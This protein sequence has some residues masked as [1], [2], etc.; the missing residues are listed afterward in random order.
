[1]EL[2]LIGVRRL[3]RDLELETERHFH[4][5]DPDEYAG[6]PAAVAQALRQAW[7]VPDGPIANL[8][9]LIESAGGVVLKA[10]FGTNK[11][12]GMSCWERDA[13]PLF[14]LNSRMAPEDLRWTIAHELGHLTMHGVPPLGD[15]EKEAD[16]FAAE[17]LAPAAQITPALRRL[18]FDRLF[19]LKATWRLSIKAL[20]FRAEAVG[21][22]DR[23][24]AVRLYKQYSA[25]G[26]NAGEPYPLPVEPTTLVES[27]I[28]IHLD[29]HGYS[30][31]ELAAG[32]GFLKPHEFNSEFS[33]ITPRSGNVV[34]M[35]GRPGEAR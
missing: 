31:E 32:V 30:P 16:E 19:P 27:A 18:A 4:T 11:L 8:T 26:Y 24:T 17:F 6:S 21:A 28:R 22:I 34:P 13:L 25:R 9:T 3:L 10:D 2:R 15:P 5:M 7:R 1:M 20:I 35:F 14:Y 23:Q 33:P 29:E 12:M